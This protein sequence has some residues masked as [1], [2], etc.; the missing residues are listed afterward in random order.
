VV[1]LRYFTVYGPRQ[2]EDMFVQR[3]LDA[4]STGLTLQIYGDGKQRRDFTYV[5]DAINATIAAGTVYLSNS[6]INVGA[7]RTI[8][9]NDVVERAHRLT[10][11]PINVRSTRARSGD[12][13]VTCADV[14]SARRL[15]GWAPTTDLVTG[16]A[17]Q[18]DW[19]ASSRS[20]SPIA[21]E[22]V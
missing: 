2:R 11:Q 5:D 22:A 20:P 16:M 14:T 18:L 15:L 4:A 19:M 21:A 6:V 7:G 9:L 3:L 1:A 10:G 17:A 13:S 8:S 12:V